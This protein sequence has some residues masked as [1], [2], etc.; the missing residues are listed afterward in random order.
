MASLVMSRVDHKT[1][2]H[3]MQ[4]S[5]LSQKMTMNLMTRKVEQ[6]LPRQGRALCD[7][8]SLSYWWA[9]MSLIR[10]AA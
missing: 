4:M 2:D 5:F 8:E 10:L 6:M 9:V 7:C 1:V 3:Q